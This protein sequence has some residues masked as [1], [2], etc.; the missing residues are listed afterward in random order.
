[1]SMQRRP[2]R[3]PCF[4]VLRGPRCVYSGD[5]V[6]VAPGGS[7]KHSLLRSVL[8]VLLPLTCCLVSGC[9]DPCLEYCEEVASCSE[10]E[11]TEAWQALVD[12]CYEAYDGVPGTGAGCQAAMDV[13]ICP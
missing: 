11:G 4:P 5:A 2:A 8:S 12:S 1:M 6:W 10:A 13:Y 7:M 9:S 3:D